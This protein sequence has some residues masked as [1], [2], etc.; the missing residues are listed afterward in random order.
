MAHISGMRFIR[1]AR[2]AKD[3]KRLRVSDDEVEAIEAAI[4][5]DPMAGDVVAGLGGARK[6][7]FAFGGR[8]KRGGGRAIYFL[9]LADDAAALLTA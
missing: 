1:T 9:L 6:L 8:G 2:C 5:S 4:T 3:P 7:R